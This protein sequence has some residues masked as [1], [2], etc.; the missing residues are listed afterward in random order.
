M[1]TCEFT[2][3]DRLGKRKCH[4]L[5]FPGMACRHCYGCNGSGRFFPLTLKTFSDVSKSINVLRN[6]LLKCT[7]GPSWMAETVSMLYERH[8]VEK[9]RYASTSKRQVCLDILENGFSNNSV[10]CSKMSSPFGSQ[11]IFFDLIWRRLHPELPLDEGEETG[12]PHEELAAKAPP[13]QSIRPSRE[14]GPTKCDAPQAYD[15]ITTTPLPPVQSPPIVHRGIM[16]S[17]QIVCPKKRYLYSQSDNDMEQ[18][19]YC[20][21]Q[22][23][24]HLQHQ[25][26]PPSPLQQVTTSYSESDFSIAMILANGF[27]RDN[28]DVKEDS[29]EG[30]NRAEV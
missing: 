20:P 4:K 8:K 11:K 7:R 10:I 19:H 14:R 27:G 6:H 13:R 9:V 3:A 28:N 17:H 25:P 29:P 21:D 16:K 2:E 24:P 5:G 18:H 22:T 26:S 23:S 12:N 30:P 15:S 1:T